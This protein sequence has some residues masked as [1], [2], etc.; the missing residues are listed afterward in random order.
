MSFAHEEAVDVVAV[1]EI[2]ISD[3]GG[4]TVPLG[5][6]QNVGINLG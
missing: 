2:G 3:A 1:H 4:V 6:G 5:D